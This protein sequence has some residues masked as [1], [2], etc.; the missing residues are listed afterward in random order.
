[1]TGDSESVRDAWRLDDSIDADKLAGILRVSG[2]QL[3]QSAGLDSESISTGND[4]TAGLVERRLSDL[5]EILELAE[6]LT[7]TPHDAFAWYQSQRLLSL[8]NH[9]AEY[10][11]R[12][13][14][15]SVVKSHLKRISNG[16]Y[17]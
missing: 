8:G 11:V 5:V 12:M 14:R 6:S 9:T 4:L 16:G 13:G 10:L 15:A 3:A 7:G 2:D 17:T 1:M